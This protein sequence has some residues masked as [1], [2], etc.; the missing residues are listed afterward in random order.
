MAKLPSRPW[1]S[2]LCLDPTL[3]L[4]RDLPS[5]PTWQPHHLKPLNNITPRTISKTVVTVGCLIWCFWDGFHCLLTLGS[6]RSVYFGITPSLRVPKLLPAFSARM[7]RMVQQIKDLHI[8]NASKREQIHRKHPVFF[9]KLTIS[10]IRTLLFTSNQTGC[11]LIQTDPS[12]F[13]ARLQSW[14]RTQT[15]NQNLCSSSC[16]VEHLRS[17]EPDRYSCSVLWGQF[18]TVTSSWVPQT[19]LINSTNSG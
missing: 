10:S 3:V 5:I 7:V 9:V 2:P 4:A 15:S 1:S 6:E 18:W 14:I 17:W 12:F 13:G 16:L 11:S 19:L 8:A